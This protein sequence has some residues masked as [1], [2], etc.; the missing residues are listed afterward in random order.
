[1]KIR[2]TNLGTHML[3]VPEWMDKPVRFKNGQATVSE[4]VGARMVKEFGAIE[5]VKPAKA[6]KKTDRKEVSDDE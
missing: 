1:M 4:E 5:E 3:Y 6:R 2:C